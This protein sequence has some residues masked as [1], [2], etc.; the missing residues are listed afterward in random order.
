MDQRTNITLCPRKLPHGERHRPMFADSP[1]KEKSVRI[2][3]MVKETEKELQFR[4]EGWV[5]A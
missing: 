2:K 1:R 5:A 3:H 4:L